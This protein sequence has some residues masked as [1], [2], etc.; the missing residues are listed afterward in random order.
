[1]ELIRALAH[2]AK[3]E[4][5]IAKDIA[6]QTLRKISEHLRQNV[7]AP[8]EIFPELWVQS[9]LFRA[10]LGERDAA[11]AELRRAHKQAVTYNGWRAKYVRSNL[12]HVHALLGDGEGALRELERLLKLPKSSAH[13]TTANGFRVNL[14][15]ASL[16]DDPRFKRI[17]DDPLN[18]A[19]LPLDI[20]DSYV[21]DD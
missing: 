4:A 1:L 2:R 3:G 17:V 14:A 12:V 18:H 15:L 6:R 19:A 13:N 7:L 9:S 5:S 11:L 20:E 8:G 16:W 10:I 21:L